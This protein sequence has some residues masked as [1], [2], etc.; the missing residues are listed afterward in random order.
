MR[1][2]ALGKEIGPLEFTRKG[3]VN[4]YGIVHVLLLSLPIVADLPLICRGMLPG[5]LSI[6]T[7]SHTQSDVF[8]Y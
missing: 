3:V 4:N 8:F 2:G 7:T 6:L 1:L 5:D